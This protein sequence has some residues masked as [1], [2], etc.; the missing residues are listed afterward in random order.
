MI[1]WAAAIRVAW[2]VLRGA[3]GGSG[4]AV[5]RVADLLGE[6]KT[7]DSDVRRAEIERKII[8]AKLVADLQRDSRLDPLSPMRIGQYLIVV[9]YG[10]WWAAV[11]IVSIFD[12]YTAYDLDVQDLPAHIHDL[13]KWWVPAILFGTVL[14]ARK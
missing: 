7:A 8:E 2:S 10:A 9:P 12:P 4:S 11:C 5:D 14:E 13:A 3:L 1:G 6:L